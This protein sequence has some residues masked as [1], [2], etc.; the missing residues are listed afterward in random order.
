ML[1]NLLQGIPLCIIESTAACTYIQRR[2]YAKRRARSPRHHARINKKWLKRYGL[3][4]EPNA[5][6]LDTSY[7]LGVDGGK[8]LVVHPTLAPLYRQALARLY[9]Q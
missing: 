5:Y 3:R 6:W 9:P 2:V 4:A 7:L 8:T 1:G